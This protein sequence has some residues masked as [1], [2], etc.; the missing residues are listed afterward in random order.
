MKVWA[1]PWTLCW[2]GMAAVGNAKTHR[3]P[4]YHSLFQTAAVYVH[5]SRGFHCSIAGW[6]RARP[7][8]GIGFA[9][10]GM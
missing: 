5:K 6:L 2:L 9:I 4:E 8:G 7:A 3:V 1:R 10:A